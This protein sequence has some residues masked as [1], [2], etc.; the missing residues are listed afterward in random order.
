MAPCEGLNQGS[1]LDSVFHKSVRQC[2]TQMSKHTLHPRGGVQE[3]EQQCVKY[4]ELMSTQVRNFFALGAKGRAL[5][6]SMSNSINFGL[7]MPAVQDNLMAMKTA[8]QESQKTS[9]S[10]KN[11]CGETRHKK[12]YQENFEKLRLEGDP[13]ADG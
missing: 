10:F 7:L 13:E 8:Q 12:W 1:V 4:E 11:L 5:E 2:Q 3:K 6:Q 9:D